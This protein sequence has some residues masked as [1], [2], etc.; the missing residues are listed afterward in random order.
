[1]N[2]LVKNKNGKTVTYRSRKKRRLGRKTVKNIEFID[3][4]GNII[5][6]LILHQ[7]LFNFA[8]LN[9]GSGLFDCSIYENEQQPVMEPQS[10]EQSNSSEPGLADNSHWSPD[11]SESYT[12]SSLPKSDDLSSYGDS[13]S[14]Y[15]DSG[16]GC[17]DSGGCGCD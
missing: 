7:H 6:D 10:Q 8:Y 14:S 2:I 17:C 3:E 13:S 11:S 12:P 4:F 1:M 9:G 5:T 16:G 15:G